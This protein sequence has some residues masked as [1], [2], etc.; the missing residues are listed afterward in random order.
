[1]DFLRTPNSVI[2]QYKKGKVLIDDYEYD[3]YFNRLSREDMTRITLLKNISMQQNQYVIATTDNYPFYINQFIIIDGKKY[4]IDSMY[5][6]DSWNE[7]NMF[8]FECETP[9]RYLVIRRSEK[10]REMNSRKDFIR[11]YN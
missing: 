11:E 7:N 6:E 4:T 2:P 3:I 10:W 8:D 9:I 1:M 5:T